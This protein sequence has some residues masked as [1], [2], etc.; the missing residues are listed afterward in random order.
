MKGRTRHDSILNMK[1]VGFMFQGGF[2]FKVFPIIIPCMGLIVS[3]KNIF[4]LTFLDFK[5]L[6]AL[7]CN[8]NQR[9]NPISQISYTAFLLYIKFDQRVQ[10]TLEINMFL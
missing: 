8:D 7:C 10:L 1:A 6:R 2:F 3:E 9:S 5:F 4:F